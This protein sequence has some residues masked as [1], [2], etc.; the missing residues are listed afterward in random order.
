[1]SKGESISALLGRWILAWL[2]LIL[3]Y[4]YA[5]DWNGMIELLSAKGVPNAPFALL[6]GL[7]INVLGSASL[8]LGF[9]AR[10]GAAALFLVTIVSTFV[11]YDYW[12]IADPASRQADFDLFARNMGIAGGLLLVIG[13]GPGKFAFDNRPGRN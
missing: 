13:T 8:L 10:A 7:V 11:I 3:T 1:M 12:N 9:H 5:R 2:F 6:S 4:R